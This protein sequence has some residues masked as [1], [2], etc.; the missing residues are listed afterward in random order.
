MFV[1]ALLCEKAMSYQTHYE[2]RFNA[3]NVE[4]EIINNQQLSINIFVV[5]RF[6]SILLA[7]KRNYEP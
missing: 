3:K 6:R 2:D 7:L 4:H 5:T 1:V